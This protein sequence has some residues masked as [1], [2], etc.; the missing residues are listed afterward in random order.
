MDTSA[1]LTATGILLA[2][3]GILLAGVA[4]LIKVVDKEKK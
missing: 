1:S 4:A 2:G 3:L